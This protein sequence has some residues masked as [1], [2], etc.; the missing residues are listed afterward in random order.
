MKLIFSTRFLV[1]L[2]DA[3]SKQTK[4]TGFKYKHE[5]IMIIKLRTKNITIALNAV[6]MIE[7]TLSLFLG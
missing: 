6:N 2:G 4:K 1:L 3:V 5:L 7:L